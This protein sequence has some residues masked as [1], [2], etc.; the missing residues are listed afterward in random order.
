M[1]TAVSSRNIGNRGLC[2]GVGS[3]RRIALYGAW[4]RSAN[5][6]ARKASAAETAS[7][8]RALASSMVPPIDSDIPTPRHA[9][10]PRLVVSVWP[11]DCRKAASVSRN[12]FA[13]A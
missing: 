4:N 6:Q 11:P 8:P 2:G 12:E 5:D 13:A 3:T 10:Q 7:S 9:V 1:V